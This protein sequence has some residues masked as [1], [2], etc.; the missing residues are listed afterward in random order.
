MD[1]KSIGR[2]QRAWRITVADALLVVVAGRELP[3]DLDAVLA[4]GAG[5]L[6]SSSGDLTLKAGQTLYAHQL[7]G[8]KAPRV[9]FAHAGDGSSAKALRKAVAAGLAP[10]QGRRCGHLAVARGG[11]R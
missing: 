5:R 8:V 10:D 1:F 4:E 2:P 11:A 9:V 3:V 6:R 7:A